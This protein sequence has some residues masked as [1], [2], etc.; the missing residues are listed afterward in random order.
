MDT[1]KPTGPG[2]GLGPD[3]ANPQIIILQGLAG[4]KV[5][6]D[7]ISSGLPALAPALN[8]ILQQ[9]QQVIPQAMADQLAGVSSAGAGAPP[10]PGAAPGALPPGMPPPGA[11]GM[12]PA[13]M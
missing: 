8:G 4:V 13:G 11:G 6:F 10:A 1:Q 5:N 3:A 9:L 7:L 12:P 2:A